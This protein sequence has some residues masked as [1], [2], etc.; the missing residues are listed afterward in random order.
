M[1]VII[2]GL[3]IYVISHRRSVKLTDI[4][5]F[6]QYAGEISGYLPAKNFRFYTNARDSGD[7]KFKMQLA[8]CPKVIS[9]NPGAD[10]LLAYI[11]KNLKNDNTFEGYDTIVIKEFPNSRFILLSAK[12]K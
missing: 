12:K 8:L 11:D 5:Y 1:L 3:E 10:T 4:D 9:D 7:V 6:N 2:I